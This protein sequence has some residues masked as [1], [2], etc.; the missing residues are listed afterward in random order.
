MQ[1][2]VQLFDKDSKVVVTVTVPAATSI[3]EWA[4]RY[5]VYRNGVYQET[6]IYRAPLGE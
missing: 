2:Q 4:G 1:T 3:I 5:F 6:S